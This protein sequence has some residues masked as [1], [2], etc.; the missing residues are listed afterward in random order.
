VHL[1]LEN[2]INLFNTF[3][4]MKNYFNTL[5]PPVSGRRQSDGLSLF[6]QRGYLPILRSFTVWAL[7]IGGLFGSM[8]IQAANWYVNDASTAGDVYTTAVGNDANAGTAAAP[9]LTITYA[10]SQAAS[11]DVIFV[12]AGTYPEEVNVNKGLTIKGPN[13]GTPGFGSRVAEAIIDGQGVRAGFLIAANNIIIDGFRIIQAHD[14]TGQKHGAI[15]A[16][17]VAS[18]NVEILNSIIQNNTVGIL[19]TYSWKIKHN[20]IDNNNYNSVPPVAGAGIYTDFVTNGLVIEN[21]I[22]NN[23][24]NNNPVILAATLGNNHTGVVFKDNTFNET[25][26]VYCVG[27]DDSQFTGNTF[28]VTVPPTDPL[29]T[30]CLTFAGACDNNVVQNNFFNGSH[31]GLRIVDHGYGLGNNSGIS[32]HNNSFASSLS[33]FAVG[34][35]SGHTGAVDATCNWYSTTNAATIATKI[36][37]TGGSVT[38]SPFLTNGTDSAPATLGF[39]PAAGACIGGI[40]QLVAHVNSV[41]V[42]ANND[43]TT[44]TGTA[45]VCNGVANSISITTAF[46]DLANLSTVSQPVRVYQT[47]NTTNVGGVA[48]CNN[49][50]AALAAFTAGTSTTATLTNP[51]MPGSVVVT[52]QAWHDLDN[53]SSIDPGEPIGDIVQYTINVNPIP[54]I[55]FTAQVAGGTP[56]NGSSD[57]PV[58]VTL[59]FC[60]GQSFSYSNYISVPGANVGVLEMLTGTGNV[61]YNGATVSVPRAQ[62]DFG[63]GGTAGYFSGTYG[64]YGLSSGTSGQ[65]VETF[66]PYYDA[67]NSGTY[68]PGDCLG[69]P[70]TITYNVSPAPEL[71]NCPASITANTSDDDNG[72]DCDTDVTWS[73]P[74]VAPACSPVTLTMSINGGTPVDVTPGASYT[75][76]FNVGSHSIAYV[77]T[78]GA[79]N[80]DNCSFSIQVIDDENP[81][82]QCFNDVVTF[83]GETSIALNVADLVD[84]SDNCGIATIV[85]TPNAITCE[86]LG[87]IVPITVTVTDVN[88]NV[89]TC[90]SNITVNG[91]P[92]G[93]SSNSNSVGCASNVIYAPGTGTWTNTA[94]SCFYASPYTSDDVAFIQ[95][96][97]CGDGSITALVN[98][99]DALATGWAGVTMRESTAVGS[100]K[101]QLMTNLSNLSRREFRS[102]TNGQSFPQQFPSQH[103]YWLRIVRS[104]NQF[105]MYVSPNGTAWYVVG[106][107]QIVMNQCIEIGLVTTNYSSNGTTST[108]F[109]NVSYTGANAPLALPSNSSSAGLADFSS[110]LEVDFS[111]FPNPTS[112]E[113][114]LDL[115]QYIGRSVRIETYSLEG[116]LLQ[117]SELD[118]VQNTLERLDLKGFQNGMY[119]VKVKSNGLPEVARRVVKQ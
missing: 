37:V 19:E 113:L 32:A 38:Y 115:T 61:T 35:L 25:Y 60:S 28:N 77:S 73:H 26:G 116:K 93:W 106:T 72:G 97:L 104:G 91:L 94:S 17:V 62:I 7:L 86:Q 79:G 39:Q 12:D 46:Q 89:S 95:R 92:C 80:T 33:E 58:N 63:V 50:Q 67:D 55:S 90:I 83:N 78:D 11:G 96:T 103:R 29:G 13:A 15:V 49:C 4:N 117:F 52:F 88:G 59:D 23:H 71:S 47:V 109:S 16:W 112:G 21:N 2:I 3:L 57:G 5:S 51:A 81:A 98:S 110:E 75:H 82:V 42:T 43:G 65:F 84:A 64:P 41:T 107:Q 53:N 14:P 119:L 30:T 68:T 1:Y 76:N 56:Q 48:W 22:F 36:N 34:N 20:L 44:D 100:K 69:T 66:T 10:I 105:A 9:F 31:R 99:I 24:Q 114:N 8:T 111:V 85:L 54:A 40:P 118:E 87:Q 6:V 70:L 27:V 18:S 45:S 108:V 102:A 74:D 101:A